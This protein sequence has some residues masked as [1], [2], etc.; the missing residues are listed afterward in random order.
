M[1][2]IGVLWD[3]EVSWDGERPFKGE[4]NDSYGYFSERAL[5]K[6]VKL[7]FGKYQ[8]YGSGRLENAWVYDGSWK[9]VRDVELDGVFDKFHFDEDT[10]K[11]K[12]QIAEEIS[13]LNHPEIEELCKDKLKT[14]QRYEDLVPETKEFS[15]DNLQEMFNRYEKVVLK[16]RFAFGG[17]GIHIIDENDEVPEVGEDYVIQSFVDSSSG[18]EG[19]AEGTHDL[20]GIVINGKLVAGYVR[21]NSEGLIS[22]VAQ[23]GTKK[24][25]SPEEFPGEALDTIQKVINDIEIDPHFISVDLFFDENQKAYIVELNSKPGLGI[26]GDDEMKRQLE[27]VMDNLAEVFKHI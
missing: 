14:Y 26:Y 23:G 24:P 21:Q 3:E 22:N 12:K 15:E 2:N 5:D 8:W 16:P 7:Y 13:I 1:K 11:L 25:L 10:K 27:P 19:I 6:N 4:S 17:E 9:K 18:I 20:R